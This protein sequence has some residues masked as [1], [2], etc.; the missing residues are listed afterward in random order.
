MDGQ[1]SLGQGQLGAG[2]AQNA[3]ILEQYR[4]AYNQMASHLMEQGQA[5]PNF[6]EW[7]AAQHAA[8][9]AQQPT[10]RGMLENLFSKLGK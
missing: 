7:A 2:L 1:S 3:A 5:A 6:T 4:P 8:T 10:R 9:Q